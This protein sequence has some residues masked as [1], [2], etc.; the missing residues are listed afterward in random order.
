MVIE[1]KDLVADCRTTVKPT[2]IFFYHHHS[3]ER[4]QT[5]GQR[6]KTEN[7]RN[8]NNNEKITSSFITPD[9]LFPGVIKARTI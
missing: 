9:K 5:N 6:I 1:V 2:T 3:S 7:V 8:E 4:R